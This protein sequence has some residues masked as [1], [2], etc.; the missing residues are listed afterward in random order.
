[1][2]RVLA[3]QSNKHNNHSRDQKRSR[4]RRRRA[5]EKL[6]IAQEHLVSK[7]KVNKINPIYPIQMHRS[8]IRNDKLLI[9]QSWRVECRSER[10]RGHALAAIAWSPSTRTKLVSR[11]PCR[12]Y[13]RNS[14][15]Y[16]ET[17]RGKLHKIE[18][19]YSNRR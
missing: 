1:M 8:N 6:P 19:G 18:K 3:A 7:I 2:E 13:S 11:Q 9:S 12:T 14:C 5:K 17:G 4:S 10:L 16:Q 15:R